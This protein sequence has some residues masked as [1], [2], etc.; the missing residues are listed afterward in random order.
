MTSSRSCGGCAVQSA[1]RTTRLSSPPASSCGTSRCRRGSL[2]E[3]QKKRWL[4]VLQALF[5]ARKDEGLSADELAE[6]PEFRAHGDDAPLARSIAGDTQTVLR[7]LHE[8]T[9]AGLI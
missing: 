9:E 4:A 3:R 2:P 5:N 1:A 6:L 7:I 8:M